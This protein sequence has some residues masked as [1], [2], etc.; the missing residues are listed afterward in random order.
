MVGWAEAGTYSIGFHLSSLLSPR[1]LSSASPLYA[2]DRR[3]V[4]GVTLASL[5]ARLSIRAPFLHSSGEA[6]RP[7][8][9]RCMI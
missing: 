9:T 5:T 3:I 1:F 4:S 7:I 2:V 8:Q 6:C